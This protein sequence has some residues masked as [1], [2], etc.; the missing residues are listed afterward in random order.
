VDEQAPPGWVEHVMWWH[1]YPLGF[2]GADATGVD[3]TPGRTLADLEPWLDYVI[4]LG[5]NGILLAP[6]FQ[7][8]THGYDT[9]N[10]YQI[11]SRLGTESDF[12]V[13]LTAARQR[14]IR[15]LLDGVFNH[16]GRSFQPPGF[17][18]AHTEDLL[19]RTD[20]GEVVTFEGHD[21][22]VS[23]N[24]AD[25]R[26]AELAI[27]VMTHWLDCGVDGWRLDA[28]YA[29][30][31][32]FW[33]DVISRV[34]AR[35]PAAY[36]VGEYIHADYPA[37]IRDGHLDSVTQYE[38]WQG[39]WHALEDR[40]LGELDWA[41]SRHNRFLQTFVP[42]TFIGNHD[43]TRIASQISD[44]RHRPHAVALLMTLG[45]TP[46]IYYGDERGESGRKEA[47]IGGD[48]TI[49]P[50]YPPSPADVDDDRNDVYS[51]HRHLIGLR[52]RHPWLVQATTRAVTLTDTHY[53][54][55]VRHD[56]SRLYVAL[57]IGDDP[58]EVHV[59]ADAVL[60]GHASGT[61]GHYWVDGHGWAV[62]G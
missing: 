25:D 9:T 56:S 7:S 46:A 23:L 17:L 18:A 59:A 53:V 27:D 31:S 51:L 55:E 14:G 2:L 36:F 44:P 47:R 6:I 13:F 49:R 3:R 35:H 60:A 11:D 22:L 58:C 41:L 61:P 37:V 28:A 10:Y 12:A 42:F 16:V 54:I 40:N 29:V 21:K 1:I 45:G 43:V 24:H 33:G 32:E 8:E 62:L 39:I 34:R 48:D 20:S 30:P 38:L 52:R 4:G 50:T 57:N 19:R 5:L 15:V 26:V